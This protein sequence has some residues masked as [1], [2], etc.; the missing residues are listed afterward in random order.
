M[1]KQAQRQFPREAFIGGRN[2]PSR[3][4]KPIRPHVCPKQRMQNMA[5][6]VLE[7]EGTGQA[8]PEWLEGPQKE[9][10]HG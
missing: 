10:A 7:I 4:T 2:I 5:Q 1:G 3:N 9:L 8:G 6:H